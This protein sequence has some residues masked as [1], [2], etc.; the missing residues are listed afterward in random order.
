MQIK[1]NHKQKQ[2]EFTIHSRLANLASC[3]S[4]PNI[5]KTNVIHNSLQSNTAKLRFE[6]VAY[7]AFPSTMFLWRKCSNAEWAKSLLSIC[8]KTENLN[9]EYLSKVF[10]IFASVTWIWVSQ[11]RLWEP[12][13]GLNHPY[14]SHLSGF[15][16]MPFHTYTQIRSPFLKSIH[17]NVA[18]HL[19]T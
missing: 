8:S 15:S 11:R 18:N 17:E 2:K 5:S 3:K 14:W 6:S 12:A 4:R 13:Q 7:H 19:R 16:N 10:G 9:L 1:T